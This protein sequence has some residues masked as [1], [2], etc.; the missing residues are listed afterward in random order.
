[1]VGRCLGHAL[2]RQGLHVGLL[3]ALVL[4]Q[5]SLRSSDAGVVDQF[6]IRNHCF[7]PIHINGIGIQIRDFE[8]N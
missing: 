5:D 1:M 7:A 6:R 8:K 2:G 3:L 4:P